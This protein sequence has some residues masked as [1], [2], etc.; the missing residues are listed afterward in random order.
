[1][2]DALRDVEPPR[3]LNEWERQAV[4]LMLDGVDAGHAARAQLE[5]AQITAECAHCPT[6]DIRIP[7]EVPPMRRPDGT[8][9]GGGFFAL[10]GTDAD[11]MF[12][13]MVLVAQSGRLTGLV[14]WRGDGER[15]DPPDLGTFARARGSSWGSPEIASRGLGHESD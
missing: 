12:V 3:P 8:P 4:A 5:S 6:V 7:R 13:E 1:V 15:L 11:G 10:H 9:A 2:E 14:V